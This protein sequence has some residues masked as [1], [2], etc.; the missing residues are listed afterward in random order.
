MTPMIRRPFPG[1]RMNPI[2]GDA[3]WTLIWAT[4]FALLVSGCAWSARAGGVG[5]VR[6]LS[7]LGVEGSAEVSGGLR[8]G[9]G[10]CLG[11]ARVSGGLFGDAPAGE[12]AGKLEYLW[13]FGANAGAV[14][15]SWGPRVVGEDTGHQVSLHLTAFEAFPSGSPVGSIGAGVIAGVGFGEE[16]VRGGWFGVGVFWEF[17]DIFSWK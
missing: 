11:G 7:E 3:K 2:H 10:L 9:R 13:F 12:V 4:L 6:D 16:N 17:S 1:A 8:C 5:T 14:G 15:L